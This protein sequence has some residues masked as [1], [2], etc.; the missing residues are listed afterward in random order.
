MAVISTTDFIR[1]GLDLRRYT[2]AQLGEVNSSTP[3]RLSLP[4]EGGRIRLLG[5][6]DFDAG[7]GS[8]SG[9]IS[10]LRLETT[11]TI[12]G[13]TGRHAFLRITGLSLDAEDFL[14]DL[15]GATMGEVISTLLSGN[16]RMTGSHWRDRLDGMLGNDTLFGA[17]GADTIIGGTGRDVLNGGNDADVLFGGDGNDRLLGDYGKDRLAGG[18]GA[19]ALLGGGGDDTLEGGLGNDTLN[20]LAGEDVFVFRGAF[21]EDRIW[22]MTATDSIVLGDSFFTGGRTAADLV[23]DHARVMSGGILLD[24]GANEIYIGGITDTDL[25]ADRLRSWSDFFG[26]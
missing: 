3:D 11:M 18:A 17:A 25:L 20:G 1:R 2:D 14:A 12:D 21:G 26:S 5:D 16:D 19:D 6:Y 7:T 10:E 24:L 4:F 8:A 13:V 9:T 23:A 15:E 22:Q